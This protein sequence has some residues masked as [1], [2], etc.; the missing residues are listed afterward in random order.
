LLALVKGGY[1]SAVTCLLA[2]ELIIRAPVLIFAYRRPIAAP[3]SM[4]EK[5]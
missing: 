2:L 3:F 4:E 5:P 1:T